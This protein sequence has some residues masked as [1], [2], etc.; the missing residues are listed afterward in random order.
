MNDSDKPKESG[1]PPRDADGISIHE[2][3][4]DERIANPPLPKKKATKRKPRRGRGSAR[5]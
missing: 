2:L 4:G 1:H 3:M 5:R